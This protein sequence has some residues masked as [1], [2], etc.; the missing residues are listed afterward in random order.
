MQL[1]S[2]SY[3]LQGRRCFRTTAIDDPDACDW[4]ETVR[5][6]APEQGQP[7]LEQVASINQIPLLIKRGDLTTAQHRIIETI[8]QL[9]RTGTT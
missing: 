6:L 5:R 7:M 2:S 1:G 3:M 8:T 4:L 9:I